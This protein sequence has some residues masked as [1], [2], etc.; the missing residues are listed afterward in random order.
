M[1]K[2]KHLTLTLDKSQ[3]RGY[4]KVP[5][6]VGKNTERIDIRYRY[7]SSPVSSEGDY[8]ISGEPRTIDLGRHAAGWNHGRGLRFRQKPRLAV[9]AGKQRRFSF[10]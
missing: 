9:P 3:E 8:C 10:R 4:I 7:P 2:I 6:Q 5:F 1:D